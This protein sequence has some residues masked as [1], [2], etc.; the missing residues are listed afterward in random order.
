MQVWAV[1]ALSDESNEIERDESECSECDESECSESACS[2]RDESNGSDESECRE[3]DEGNESV[4]S[5][6]D[7]SNEIDGRESNEPAR[8]EC[9]QSDRNGFNTHNE[10]EQASTKRQGGASTTNS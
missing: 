8:N 2:W 10:A 7:E 4:C 6:R 3:R 5:E 1:S 9:V